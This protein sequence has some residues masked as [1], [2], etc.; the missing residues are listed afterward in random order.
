MRTE[1]DTW[2]IT[3]SVGSTAL[4][5][6]AARALAGR[7]PDPLAVDPFAEIFL[8]AAGAEWADLLDGKAADHP[9]LAP[10]FGAVFQTFMA[11]RTKYFDDYFAAASAAGVGQV[12]ILA[13]GL[14]A[15]AYRLPWP[16]GTVVYELDQPSVL[17]F[18]SQT[19]A[20]HGDEPRAERRE[21]PIDL[22]EDWP[23]AL[24]A[25]GF[26]V[27][28]PTAWLAEGLL[29]YLPAVAVDQLFEHIAQA[30]A[31]GSRVAIEE[32]GVVPE[33]A[34]AALAQQPESP[35]NGGADWVHLIYN[36]QRSD[37]AQW[38]GAHGWHTAGHTLLDYL[39]VVGRDIGSSTPDALLVPSLVSLVTA[40]R[41]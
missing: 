3:T 13:A 7:R 5:A 34:R 29:L 30:S 21:V 10:G 33:Q 27:T 31:P 15:R 37:A 22:R 35:L 20:A 32:L 6:A 39:A 19:L 26:D 2:D 18:K 1:G 41:P 8:R 17:E 14:D 12:V 25:S 9:L 11:A 36:E 28:A 4:F 40:I 16:D 38:F 24:R 23:K